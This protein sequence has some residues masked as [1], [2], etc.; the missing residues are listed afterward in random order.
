MDKKR[1]RNMMFKKLKIMCLLIFCG[2]MLTGCGQMV[3]MTSQET[4]MVTESMAGLLLKYDKNYKGDLVYQESKD[5]RAEI[6][7]KENASKNLEVTKAATKTAN[8]KKVNK[9]ELKA[10]ENSNPG[11]MITADSMNKAAEKNKKTVEYVH[12]ND[13]IGNK[14]FKIDYQKYELS[15]SYNGN[16]SNQAFTID[17]SA[18]NQLLIAYFNITNLTN[19]SQKLNLAGSNIQYQ[20]NVAE[21][22]SY[23]PLI[24]LLINDMQYINMDFADGETKE[25]VILF[26]IPKDTDLSNVE[27]AV[28]NKANISNFKMK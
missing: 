21:G 2:G 27:M 4:N 5:L 26:E 9:E 25:A 18:N 10:Q 19:K 13:T 7:S 15:N 28:Y 22:N 12:L 23:K 3:D 16:I 20:L 17:A 1:G 6:E 24:T 8:V 14:N 11:K